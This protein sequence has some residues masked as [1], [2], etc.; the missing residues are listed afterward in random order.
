MY[1]PLVVFRPMPAQAFAMAAAD[2]YAFWN[3]HR[4]D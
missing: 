2:I 1:H 4:F 3:S